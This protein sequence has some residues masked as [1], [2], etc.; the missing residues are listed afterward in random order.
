MKMDSILLMAYVDGELSAEECQEVEKEIAVSPEAAEFVAQ[1]QTARLPYAEAFAQQK[2]PPVPDSLTRTVAAMARA[3]AQRTATPGANDATV[4]PDAFAP[5]SAAARSRLRIAPQWLAVA[6]VAG[7][8][9]YGAGM[10]YLPG[11]G[12]G[13]NATPPATLAAA[14]PEA[15]SWVAAAA[16]Y[17]QLYSR[18]TVAQVPVNAEVTAQTVNEIQHQDGL[19]VRI[20]DLRAAGLTFKRVQRLRF[21]DKP[22]VQIVY[23]PPQGGPIALC[24]MKEARPDAAL[25]EQHIDSMNVVTWRH[26]DLSYALIGKPEGTDLSALAKHISDSNVQT[27]FGDAGVSMVA[28]N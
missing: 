25:A 9:C 24:V 7:L 1:L 27:L 16:G 23:L 18:E 11:L 22:L 12:S 2:L 19:D 14:N 3:H 10:R 13:P 21:H 8:F 4:A 5:P 15:S 6:F 26:A 17:Q 28:A 20:P